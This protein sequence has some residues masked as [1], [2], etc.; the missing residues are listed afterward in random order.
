MPAHTFDPSNISMAFKGPYQREGG[1]HVGAGKSH[2]HPVLRGKSDF[3]SQ[4]S[5]ELSSGYEVSF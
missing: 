2:V 1:M 4:T 3:T 5:I